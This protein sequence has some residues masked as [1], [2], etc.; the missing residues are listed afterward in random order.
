MW[1]QPFETTFETHERIGFY[2]RL[3]VQFT[4]NQIDLYF[5]IRV[6]RSGNFYDEVTRECG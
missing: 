1:V 4:S 5:K 6:L 3:T 2:R